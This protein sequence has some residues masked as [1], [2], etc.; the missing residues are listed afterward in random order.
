MKKNRYFCTEFSIKGSS[1]EQIF[2]PYP[3]IY[4]VCWQHDG[5]A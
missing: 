3:I 2:C 5:A 1:Y 4:N